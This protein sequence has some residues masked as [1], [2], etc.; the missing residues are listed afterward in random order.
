[1]SQDSQEDQ[2]QHLTLAFGGLVIQ[3]GKASSSVRHQVPDSSDTASLASFSVV[4][5][6]PRQGALAGS[7]RA[8]DSAAAGSTEVSQAAVPQAPTRPSVWSPGWEIDLLDARIPSD[9]D[10]VD[11]QPVSHL[12]RRLRATHCRWSPEAR[13]GRALAVGVAARRQLEDEQI[14]S[15]VP[16]IP[17]PNKIYV[18]LRGGPSSSAPGWTEHY[19]T[20][21]AA[22][23]KGPH[24][25]F[26]PDVVC[27]AFP[28]HSEAEAYCIGARRPW[29][30]MLQQ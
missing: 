17:F 29:P 26:H 18:I 11:L 13:L 10:P 25:R 2:A 12:F 27:H 6:V 8:T 21:I 5:E 22:E 30:P 23:V 16:D 24:S 19:L 7:E 9:F 1:M 4:S 14:V 15:G 3:I 28:T 20:F